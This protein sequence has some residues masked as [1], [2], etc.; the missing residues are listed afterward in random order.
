MAGLK[1][2][3]TLPTTLEEAGAMIRLMTEFTA[4][5]YE[6]YNKVDPE[7]GALVFAQLG[8]IVLTQ[9]AIA[10]RGMDVNSSSSVE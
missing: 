3:L 6:K 5:Y 10:Q 2:G 8:A 9:L 4:M 1:E 7:N